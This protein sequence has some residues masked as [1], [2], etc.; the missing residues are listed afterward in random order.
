MKRTSVFYFFKFSFLYKIPI[1]VCLY[2]TEHLE[3]IS[4][5]PDKYPVFFKIISQ[6]NS[7]GSLTLLLVCILFPFAR[8]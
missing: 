3:G 6:L 8:N 4:E 1:F 5:I 2:F 7:P